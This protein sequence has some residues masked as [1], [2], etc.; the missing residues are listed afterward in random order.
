MQ[1]I[2]L[3]IASSDEASFRQF[4]DMYRPKVYTV[5]LRISGDKNIAEDVVQDTFLKVWIRRADLTQIENIEAWLYMIAKNAILNLVKK[6]EHYKKYAQEEVKEAILR[7]FPQ[8]D[9]LAQEKDFQRILEEAINRLP[10]K[11]RQ[12]YILSKQQYLKREEVAK[13]LNVSPETIKSNLEKAMKSIRAYCMLHLKD[14]PIVLLLH[15]FS[16]NI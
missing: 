14:L 8:A 7:V 2:I 1:N 5:A 9:Y 10:E 16:K 13:E 11:Q 15:F 4:Y 3:G 6:G 12:A